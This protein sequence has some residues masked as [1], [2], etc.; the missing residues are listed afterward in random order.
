MRHE[1]YIVVIG[2]WR[3]NETVCGA[4]YA[5]EAEANNEIDRLNGAHSETRA[6]FVVREID[7]TS[8]RAAR[9]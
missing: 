5:T 2:T 1:I 6:Y 4:V 3:G 8:L 7:A 9:R